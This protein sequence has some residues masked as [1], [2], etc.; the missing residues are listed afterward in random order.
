MNQIWT[1]WRMNY[2]RG[3]RESVDSCLFC[4]LAESSGQ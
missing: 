2:I 1:P 4:R 3:E